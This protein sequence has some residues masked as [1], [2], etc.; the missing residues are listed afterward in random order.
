MKKRGSFKL[1]R[2]FVSGFVSGPGKTRK[3]RKPIPPVPPETQVAAGGVWPASLSDTCRSSSP[4]CRPRLRAFVDESGRDLFDLADAPRPDGDVPAP[5]RFLPEYDNVLLS[6]ADRARV[7]PDRRPVPLFAGDGA[8]AGTLLV[9][10]D[11]RATWKAAFDGDQATIAVTAAP[12]L[13]RREADDV[14]A[15]GVRLLGFLAPSMSA[16]VVVSAFS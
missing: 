11:F 4:G 3:G 16:D 8:R 14:R 5:V 6:H 7:I 10:G 1:P 12:K 9:D 2:F 13:S 15:E